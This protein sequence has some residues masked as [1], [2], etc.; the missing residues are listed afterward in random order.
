MNTFTPNILHLFEQYCNG[1]PKPEETCHLYE[2]MG[3]S[4]ISFRSN[5]V[6]NLSNIQENKRVGNSKRTKRERESESYCSWVLQK[7]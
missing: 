6:A 1:M 5:G 7:V 3:H 4:P 2:K